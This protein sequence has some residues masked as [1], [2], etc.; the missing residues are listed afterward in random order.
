MLFR[1]SLSCHCVVGIRLSILDSIFQIG[2]CTKK[3]ELRDKL[4]LMGVEDELQFYLGYEEQGSSGKPRRQVAAELIALVQ[5]TSRELAAALGTRGIPTEP[6]MVMSDKPSSA[7]A[8]FFKGDAAKLW[9]EAGRGWELFPHTLLIDTKGA[10]WG[11]TQIITAGPDFDGGRQGWAPIDFE[12]WQRQL[13]KDTTAGFVLLSSS[14]SLR[15]NY[16]DDSP[17]LMFSLDLRTGSFNRPDYDIR[18]LNEHMVRRAAE[19]ISASR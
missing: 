17:Q 6:I 16:D 19:L 8:Y 15:V 11:W 1:S 10:L 18:P 2:C 9:I 4:L 3:S 12:F 14:G 5:T 13:S 7:I